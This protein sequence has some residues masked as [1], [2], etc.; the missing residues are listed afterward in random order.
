MKVNKWK[1]NNN[2]KKTLKVSKQL[3]K[4]N[5][6]TI[7]KL[8]MKLFIIMILYKLH[9]YKIFLNKIKL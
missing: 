6:L 8:I 3:M 5:N 7:N 1:Y 4:V 9:K 2:A